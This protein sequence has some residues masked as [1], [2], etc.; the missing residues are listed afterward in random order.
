MAVRESPHNVE[1]NKGLNARF[2]SPRQCHPDQ[3]RSLDVRHS[4]QCWSVLSLSG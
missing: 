4:A 1:D 3:N 2:A